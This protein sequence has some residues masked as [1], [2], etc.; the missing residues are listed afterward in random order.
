MKTEI[1]YGSV[2]V[3]VEE[4]L[5]LLLTF[6]GKVDQVVGV[7]ME[8]LHIIKQALAFIQFGKA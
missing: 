7:R 1:F 8:L 6:F 4:R 5:M 3:I 2:A